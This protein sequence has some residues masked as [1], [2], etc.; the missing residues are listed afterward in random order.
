MS[1]ICPNCKRQLDEFLNSGL[2]GCPYCY[3][4]FKEEVEKYLACYQGKLCHKGKSPLILGDNKELV[5]VYKELV[6]KK[7]K[8]LLDKNFNQARLIEDS[9]R[10]LSSLLEER[11]LK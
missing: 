9:L 11:G 7:Q 2:L 5:K 6:G 10:E 4:A 8:A 1:K 3:G